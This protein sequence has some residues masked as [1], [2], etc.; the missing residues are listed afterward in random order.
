MDIL[1][2]FCLFFP[3]NSDCRRKCNEANFLTV[4]EK[5]DRSH[6][7]G[8]ALVAGYP[9]CI[10]F[11]YGTE[12]NLHHQTKRFLTER[13]DIVRSN[14]YK[15]LITG[16]GQSSCGTLSFRAGTRINFYRDKR[17]TVKE[18]PDDATVTTKVALPVVDSKKSKNK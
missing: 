10:L 2:S 5:A 16:C 7:P 4:P 14:R 13:N 17:S 9:F 8:F 18:R 15:E 1:D 11:R 12:R 3:V 6:Q